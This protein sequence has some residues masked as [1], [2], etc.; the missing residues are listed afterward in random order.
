MMEGN[1]LQDQRRE[2]WYAFQTEKANIGVGTNIALRGITVVRRMFTV[3]PRFPRMTQ[4]Q[5]AN[6]RITLLPRSQYDAMETL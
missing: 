4:L 3:Y 1:M 5:N 6:I 2:N